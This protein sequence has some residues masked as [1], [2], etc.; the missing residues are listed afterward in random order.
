MAERLEIEDADFND[1]EG[2]NGSGTAATVESIRTATWD[3]RFTTGGRGSGPGG[4]GWHPA[5]DFDSQKHLQLPPL[6]VELWHMAL[7]MLE[8]HELGQTS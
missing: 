3:S 6:P 4:H 1:E 7:G 8:L 2:T 5:I